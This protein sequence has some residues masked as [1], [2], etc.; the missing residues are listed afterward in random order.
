MK[1]KGMLTRPNGEVEEKEIICHFKSM[2]DEHPNIKNVPVLVID[3]KEQ[4]NGNNVLEFFWEK[5]GL[6]QAINDDA[7]WSEVKSV[8]IDIIK[9]NFEV[10]GV[11]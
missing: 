4:N 9:M 3:K 6:Y 10:V 11:E 1:E 2:D 5:D 8:I 7:A